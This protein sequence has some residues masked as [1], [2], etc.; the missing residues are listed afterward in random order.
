[1]NVVS[2]TRGK[3]KVAG[4]AI[5]VLQCNAAGAERQAGSIYD[6]AAITG[7]TA[8]IG[9]NDRSRIAKHFDRSIDLARTTLNCD[10]IDNRIGGSS[11]Q[12][13]IGCYSP[14]K[15]RSSAN[16]AVIENDTGCRNIELLVLVERQASSV[17]CSNVDYRCTTWRRLDAW[18]KS[19]WRT[20]ISDGPNWHR[21]RALS[22]RGRQHAHASLCPKIGRKHC[23]CD[24]A[25]V[26]VG[27]Q[28]RPFL[29]FAALVH[30]ITPRDYAF[31]S[32]LATL[33]SIPVLTFK[34][35]NGASTRTKSQILKTDTSNWR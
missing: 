27:K 2:N 9:H 32:S 17:R 18:L 30:H 26:L 8:G 3:I 23:F 14:S 11:C 22:K 6:T 13:W 7:D 25:F 29:L 4:S 33:G 5:D 35:Y 1:M 15:Q 20:W 16:L 21:R 24:A 10:L 19:K 34:T 31:H 28:H 12:M